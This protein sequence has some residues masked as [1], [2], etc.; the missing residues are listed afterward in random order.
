MKIDLVQDG[1]GV[2][3]LRVDGRSV[4]EITVSEEMFHDPRAPGEPSFPFYAIDV[5]GFNMEDAIPPLRTA[6]ELH[7]DLDFEI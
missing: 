5:T 4:M 7:P 2:V 3:R 6:V 1:E